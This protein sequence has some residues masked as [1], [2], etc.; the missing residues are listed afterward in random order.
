MSVGSFF[1]SVFGGN[2][3]YQSL[4]PE[5][6]AQLYSQKQNEYETGAAVNANQNALAEALKAQMNGGGPNLANE[7]LKMATN[8]NI[9]QGAG[10]IGSQKGINP[11]LATRLIANQTANANQEAAGQSSINRMAQ[12]L[13]A[14]KQLAGVY[15]QQG[16]LAN[17]NMNSLGNLYLGAQGINAGVAKQN[18]ETAGNYG[19]GFMGGL[20]TVL[21]GPGMGGGGGGGGGGGA[22]SGMSG[23]AGGS[24]GEAMGS[25]TMFASH[26]GMVPGYDEGG[27]IDDGESHYAELPIDPI[28][29]LHNDITN[30]QAPTAGS[31]MG[32]SGVNGNGINPNVATSSINAP[33]EY[34]GSYAFGKGIIDSIKRLSTMGMG[35][36]SGAEVPGNASVSG[37]STKNDKVPAMLSP[38]EIV[39][40]RS[41]TMSGDAPDK[42]AEFV[43]AIQKSHKGNEKVEYKHVLAA[44]KHMSDRLAQLEAMCAG[45]MVR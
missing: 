38:K 25:G 8:R 11:A 28:M 31:S 35:A 30:S 13:E 34:K 7:Q 15:G 20:G 23:A 43:K 10:M 27:E 19:G 39:L 22:A 4:T 3:D 36:A 42:A 24:A 16:Q 21:S 14:Q 37:D 17:A 29:P 18:A 32:G 33:A 5:Q 26:G 9:A 45:G 2:N 44:H 1:G 41:V 40:P 12:Q 6:M